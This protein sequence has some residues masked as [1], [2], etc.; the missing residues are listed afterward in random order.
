[1][2]IL[3]RFAPASMTVPQY[4]EALRRLEELGGDFASTELD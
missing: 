3:V 1:M 4:D 2:S